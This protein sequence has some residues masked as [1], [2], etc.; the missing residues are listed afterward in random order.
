MLPAA[1]S[2]EEAEALLTI[3][4]AHPA[5]VRR[6]GS[7]KPAD[8]K[9][10]VD[11]R[12]RRAGGTRANGDVEALADI[13]IDHLRKDSLGRDGL[14]SAHV[15]QIWRINSE[16]GARSFSP[17]SV[18][19]AAMSETLCMVRARV[20]KRD[21]GEVEATV[22]A[23][24][25]VVERGSSM[26]FDSRSRDLHFAQLEPGDVVEIEYHLLPAAEVNPWAGYYARHGSVPRFACRRGCGGG[27]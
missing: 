26:Y 8:A 7:P 17:R 15:Q 19:Y 25:P 22:S 6:A 16:Q 13:R 20:L 4:A 9:F 14:T 5:G 11:A 1:D 21:G 10:L 23:D 12:R 27:W 18:M 24:Q 3:A 2:A